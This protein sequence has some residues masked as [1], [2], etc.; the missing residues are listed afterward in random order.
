VSDLGF[1]IAVRGEAGDLT[2][3]VRGEIDAYTGRALAQHLDTALATSPGDVRIDL[4]DVRFVDSSGLAVVVAAAKKLRDRGNE[5][6]VESPSRR[7]AKLFEM[8]GVTKLV[9]VQGKGTR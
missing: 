8:T 4:T 3:A 5:L 2:L 9:K 7:V 1:E 6:V